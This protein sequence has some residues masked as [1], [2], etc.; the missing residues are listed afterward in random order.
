[1]ASVPLHLDA[2]SLFAFPQ[3]AILAMAHINK[4]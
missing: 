1:M 2:A 4:D 3:R